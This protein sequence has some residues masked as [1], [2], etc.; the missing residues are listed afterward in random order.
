[1]KPERSAGLVRRWARSY[2]RG[3]PAATAR[4]RIEEIDADLHDQIAHERAQGAGER[5]IALGILTRMVRGLAADVSWRG[6][7]AKGT[8]AYRSA[9]RILLAVALILLLPLLAMLVTD[10]VAW[11]P[12]DFGVAGALLVGIALMQRA[13]TRRAGNVAYRVAAGV[14]LAAALLLVWAS[15]AV[16]VIGEEGDPA[17][18]MYLGVLAVGIVGAAVARFRP[19]G[20]ARALLAMALAQMSVAAI[21]LVAGKHQVPISS[22][23][24]ILGL[25]GFFAALFIGSALLFRRAARP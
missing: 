5:R 14:A 22:V 3:L 19:P 6:R 2:T 13:A 17:D 21:A 7:H 10:E 16:G 20:M 24:E 1:M 4:R 12:A 23:S 8:P 25:N 9:V 11:G 18:L 15:L